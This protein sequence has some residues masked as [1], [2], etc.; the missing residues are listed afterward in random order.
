MGRGMMTLRRALLGALLGAP[1]GGAPRSAIRDG[2]LL[3]DSAPFF[4]RGLYTGELLDSVPDSKPKDIHALRDGMRLIAD[5]GFNTV[6]SY[7]YLPSRT[8][9]E[10]A[11]F[12]DAAQAHGLFVIADVIYYQCPGSQGRPSKTRQCTDAR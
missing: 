5:A 10:T 2:V 11:A 4:V 1:L 6:L 8:Q 3:V 7:A 9:E 12:L